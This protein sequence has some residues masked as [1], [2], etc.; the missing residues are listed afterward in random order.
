LA[1]QL[2]AEREAL[3]ARGPIK[4][5][6]G[7]YIALKVRLALKQTLRPVYRWAVRN[8]LGWLVPLRERLRGRLIQ[9]EW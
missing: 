4:G 7:R 9:K 8:G 1:E 6:R 2:W 3:L 5:E